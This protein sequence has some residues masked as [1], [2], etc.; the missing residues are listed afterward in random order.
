MQAFPNFF[1]CGL[2]CAKIGIGLHVCRVLLFLRSGKL[3]F[4]FRL[5]KIF[6]IAE[7]GLIET[8]GWQYGMKRSASD[9]LSNRDEVGT[10]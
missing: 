1:G 8:N 5:V 9:F 10:G 3:Y 6:F 2:P 4:C 7:I